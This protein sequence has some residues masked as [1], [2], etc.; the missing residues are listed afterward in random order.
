MKRGWF[1]VIVTLALLIGGQVCNKLA[2]DR[3][4]G[5]SLE[6]FLH[7]IFI[8]TFLVLVGRGFTWLAALKTLPLSAAYP[9]LSVSFP[10]IMIISFVLFGEPIS[11]KNIAGSILILTGVSFIAKEQ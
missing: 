8:I 2:A 9:V 5:F 11:I 4:S 10:A 1:W 6:R 3:F 7:P